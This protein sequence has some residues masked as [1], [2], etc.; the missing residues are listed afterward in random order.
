MK[1]A[2]VILITGISTGFGKEIALQL[3]NQGHVVYGT[4]R[5]TIPV[6]H[7]IN[8]IL[9]ELID[10]VSIKSAA[11]HVVEREGKI[12]VLINNAGMHLGGPIEITPAEDFERQMAIGF[13]GVVRLT[14]AVLPTMRQQGSGLIIN[15]SSIGGLMGLPFQGFYSA[16][17]FAIEGFSESLRM[18]VNPF[19][20]KVVV[21]NPGDFRTSNTANRKNILLDGPYLG[22]YQKTLSIIESDE[23]GGWPPEILAHKI[24]KII[25]CRNPKQRYIIGSLEQ[26]MAV[27]IKRLLPG[28]MF[29]KMLAAH[30]GMKQR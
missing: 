11:K 7:R 17:K 18:E 6:D 10:P 14:Q 20:I 28:P 19:N 5:K 15:V 9:M 27:W 22:Q 2:K 23:I 30:Y 26:K 29:R 8:T 12:D 21:I 13:N 25:E 24:C 3:A 4:L 1:S 16:A